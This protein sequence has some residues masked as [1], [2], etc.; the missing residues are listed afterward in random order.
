MATKSDN[1]MREPDV[2]CISDNSDEDEQKILAN[3]LNELASHPAFH[4]EAG[5]CSRLASNTI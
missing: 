5:K 4:Y 2:M 1:Y 3:G